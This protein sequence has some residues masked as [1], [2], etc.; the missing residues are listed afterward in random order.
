[1]FF[2]ESPRRTVCLYVVAAC[3]TVVCAAAAGVF[4]GVLPVRVLMDADAVPAVPVFILDPGHGGEDGGAVA[5]DGTMEKDL[6]LEISL[7]MGELADFL[8]YPTVLTRH[9]DE[10]LYDRYDDLIDYDGKKKTYDLRNRLR[11]AEESGG[12]V[13]CSIHMNKFPSP[14]CKGL[15]VYY[16]PEAEASK[17]CAAVLQSFARTF[18]DAGNKREI[19]KA[20]SSIYLLHRIRMPAVLVECG[21]LS[22]PEECALLNTSAYRRKT[23]AVLITALAEGIEAGITNRDS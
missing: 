21:F 8:G 7:T 14:S 23:A 19:K 15:Q 17:S 1:M 12:A 22:N 11:Y 18:L 9:K 10:M 2:R 6:N 13:F 5:E 20:D 3:L 16:G 4:T